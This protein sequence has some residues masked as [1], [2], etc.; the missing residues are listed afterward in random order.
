MR[1]Q[2]GGNTENILQ[3]AR[4]TV[5][6]EGSRDEEIDPIV[7]K[8][9]LRVNGLT[10][11]SVE[12]MGGCDNVRS[13][14]QAL[15]RHHPSYYFLIDRDDQD[16]NTVESSWANF[17]DP[18]TYN[19]LIWRK[20]E[21]EN[22][23]IDP[24]YIEKSGHLKQDVTGQQL[25]QRILDECNRRIFLDAA[26][27]TLAALK[28]GIRGKFIC[29][30]S[31]PEKFRTEDDGVQQLEEHQRFKELGES[32]AG[33]FLEDRVINIYSEFVREL[34]GGVLPLRY[35]SGSWLERMSGKEIFRC[36]ANSCFRVITRDNETLQGKKQNNEIA[37]T[38]VSLP[39]TEQPTDFQ[40][41]LELLKTRVDSNP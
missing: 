2:L 39:C 17:P 28:R 38:L 22:Y 19:M 25:R 21:L 18:S 13:A 8:E 33:F 20:R 23:F 4:H 41:L 16:E 29:D 32:I 40:Q 12:T 9:L 36:I 6:V 3:G 35:G 27:L 26:N 5:F 14:A 34:S 10:Q 31:D 30:F 1:L 11:I 37:K 7:I 15:I 24:V